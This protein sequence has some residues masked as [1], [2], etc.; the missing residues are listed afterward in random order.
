ML[1]LP[2]RE[3]SQKAEGGG[4]VEQTESMRPEKPPWAGPEDSS[5]TKGISNALVRKLQH[6][7]KAQGVQTSVTVA[8]AALKLDSQRAW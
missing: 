8:D 5:F 3:K 6:L 4:M 2:G 1:N 7:S